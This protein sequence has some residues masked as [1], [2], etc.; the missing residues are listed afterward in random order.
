MKYLRKFNESNDIKSDVSDI[1]LELEDLGLNTITYE[2]NDEEFDAALSS[3][4]NEI[5]IKI[6]KFDE[7][8]TETD[9]NITVDVLKRIIDRLAD[10]NFYIQKVGIGLYK[11]TEIIKM[12]PT[13]WSPSSPETRLDIFRKKNT[14]GRDPEWEDIYFINSSFLAKG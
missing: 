5:T 13:L 10:Y 6:N 4:E 9:V 8:F 11:R 3:W 1:L 12:Q 14:S 2:Y 7:K